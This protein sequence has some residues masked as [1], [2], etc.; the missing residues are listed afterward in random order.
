MYLFLF[1]SLRP[2]LFGQSTED[3]TVDDWGADFVGGLC[4]TPKT[5]GGGSMW[6]HPELDGYDCENRQR[7]GDEVRGKCL[8][9]RIVCGRSCVRVYVC[10]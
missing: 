2:Q 5:G 8:M 4:L 1:F 7:G 3:D 10:V 6:G 9:F